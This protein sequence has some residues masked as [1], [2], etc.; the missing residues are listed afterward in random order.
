MFNKPSHETWQPL[1]DGEMIHM[2]QKNLSEK[3]KIML[4]EDDR[5]LAGEIECFLTKWGYEA[6]S[7]EDFENILRE[8]NEQKPQLVLMDINLPNYDGFY[9]CRKLRQISHVPI[10]YISSRGTDGDKLMGIAQGGDDYVEKPFRLEMLKAKIEAI[11]RRTYEY[12]AGDGLFRN[13]ILLKDGLVFDSA[14]GLLFWKDRG[15]EL[16]KTERRVLAKL[17]EARPRVVTR[18]ELMMDLWDT[19]EYL[20]DGTLT[21]L[22]S[23]LRSKLK[24]AC[25]EEIILTK[26]G[27]GYFIS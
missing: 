4:I 20:S 10:I 26:K 13:R 27:Q 24:A 3:M 8:F 5:A 16:T 14:S 12:G 22:V 1:T 25:G 6:V 19:D 17:A 23:R 2:E 11:L 7:A 9:W 18:E 15:I 21:T